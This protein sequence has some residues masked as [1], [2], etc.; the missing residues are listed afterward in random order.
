[1]LL[2]EYDWSQGKESFLFPFYLVGVVDILFFECVTQGHIVL[3]KCVA[4]YYWI[5]TLT[6]PGHA[7]LVELLTFLIK[8]FH[9]VFHC[10]TRKRESTTEHYN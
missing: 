5:R 7:F 9:L 1:M 4:L 6:A 8:P 10:L 2:Q 3:E